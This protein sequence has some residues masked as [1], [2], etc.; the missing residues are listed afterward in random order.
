MFEN[1]T[2]T[3]NVEGCLNNCG[4]RKHADEFD[5]GIG[6]AFADLSCRFNAIELGQADV[7]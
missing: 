6:I 2:R 3:A 4:V 1:V 5:F 7:H